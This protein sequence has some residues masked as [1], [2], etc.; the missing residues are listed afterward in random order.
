[1]DHSANRRPQQL[2][3]SRP[4]VEQA[5]DQQPE[6][7]TK[8]DIWTARPPLPDQDGGRCAHEKDLQ[9]DHQ[10]FHAAD[11]TWLAGHEVTLLLILEG[12]TQSWPLHGQAAIM[13]AKALVSAVPAESP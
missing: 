13:A 2:R 9:R 1:M 10:D 3:T 5:P 7:P 4:D 12:L 6:R 11:A 8:S